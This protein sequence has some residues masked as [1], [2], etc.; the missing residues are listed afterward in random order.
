MYTHTHS[1]FPPWGG[2]GRRQSHYSVLYYFIVCFPIVIFSPSGCLSLPSLI[3]SLFISSYPYTWRNSSTV[4]E[5]GMLALSKETPSNP[6]L[7]LMEVTTQ[8]EM[9]LA[10]VCA[11]KPENHRLW[12]LKSVLVWHAFS[13]YTHVASRKPLRVLRVLA[14][15]VAGKY[16]LM[17]C[18]YL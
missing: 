10:A 6:V 16:T 9:N 12:V 3:S 8:L 1:P 18:V 15:A 13:T 11:K 14:W 17:S 5:A 2:Q 7:V 4:H